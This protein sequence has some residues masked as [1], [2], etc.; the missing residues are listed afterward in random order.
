S[1]AFSSKTS[2]I[3]SIRASISSRSFSPLADKF[4]VGV[5]AVVVCVSLVRRTCCCPPPS[6]HVTMPAHAVHT[7]LVCSL[8][9]IRSFCA[10]S[11]AV[12]CCLCDNVSDQVCSGLRT[13]QQLLHVAFRT[14]CW[15]LH[16]DAFDGAIPEIKRDRIP[17]HPK[18]LVLKLFETLPT[19]IGT[20]IFRWVIH[21]PHNVLF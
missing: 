5:L 10:G 3:S 2:S 8:I 7:A 12:Q 15:L 20:R 19:E 13:V 14:A 18:N 6:A 4:D 1:S 16:H 21:R 11:I 17:I 9:I